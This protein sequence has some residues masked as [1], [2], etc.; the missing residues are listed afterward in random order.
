MAIKENSP[1]LL[2]PLHIAGLSVLLACTL[3]GCSPSSNDE[4][5][6]SDENTYQ[7]SQT[8]TDD[9]QQDD[10]QIEAGWRKGKLHI[11][12]SIEQKGGD[13]Q[14]SDGTKMV[15]QAK[16]TLIAISDEDVL[17]VDDLR[18]YVSAGPLADTNVM[19]YEPFRAVDMD[20][21]WIT[22]SQVHYQADY[23]LISDDISSTKTGEYT[24]KVTRIYLQG[25]HPSLFGP[26]YEA[27]LRIS[28]E[29]QLKTHEVI[30][31]TGQPPIANNEDKAS[32]EDLDFY[33]HPVPNADK[34]NDY[35]Y[36]PAMT[37]QELKETME[38]HNLETLGILNELYKDSLPV[39]TAIRAGA[40]S[41]ATKDSLTINWEYTGTKEVGLAVMTGVPA[42]AVKDN[43]MKISIQLTA[44][45]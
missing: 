18:P 13:D 5:S 7:D 20:K 16:S 21:N 43:Q 33:L 42:A 17:V 38:K 30:S 9:S 34:L 26:G 24:A 4:Q 39:Q 36:L 29:G 6:T 2:R 23:S 44:N 12:I 3:M 11:E 37:P 10:Q 19:D 31:G 45:P 28:T 35:D 15:S 32:S 25:L 14:S 40:V 1:S 27:D 22:S 8:Q 41:K